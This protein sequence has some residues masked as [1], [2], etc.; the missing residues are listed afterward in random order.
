MTQHVPGTLTLVEPFVDSQGRCR[1]KLRCRQQP[2]L[3]PAD[4]NKRNSANPAATLWGT[5]QQRNAAVPLDVDVRDDQFPQATLSLP[6]L[7][8]RPAC[9]L[10]AVDQQ[11][12]RRGSVGPVQTGY[13]YL[14][15]GRVASELE[16]DATLVDS[17][18]QFRDRLPAVAFGHVALPP[19]EVLSVA[20]QGQAFA[21]ACRL[22]RGSRQHDIVVPGHALAA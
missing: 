17:G 1:G 15:A 12:E 14:V 9:D 18:W 11:R 21:L 20:G 19:L 5:A 2:A 13:R 8:K 3:K 10:V 4:R 16:F 7:V 6:G 22:R